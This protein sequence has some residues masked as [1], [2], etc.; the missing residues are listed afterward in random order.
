MPNKEL[1]WRSEPKPDPVRVANDI[2]QQTFRG[3]RRLCQR[4][5]DKLDSL[6]GSLGTT[7][8]AQMVGVHEEAIKGWH[9]RRMV[10]RTAESKFKQLM[11]LRLEDLAPFESLES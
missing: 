9:R 2:R 6:L 7:K 11:S 10:W 4:E 1:N 3:P 8:L 5:I